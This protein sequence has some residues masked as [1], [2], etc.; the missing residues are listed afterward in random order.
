MDTINGFVEVYMDARGHKGAWEALVYY[1]NP[2][3]TQGIRRL[4][5]AAQWF[6][7]RMPWAPSTGSRAYA[8]SPRTR[9]TS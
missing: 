3:K 6:E 1:V 8:A 9:S 5:D 4:A 2:E 7:D